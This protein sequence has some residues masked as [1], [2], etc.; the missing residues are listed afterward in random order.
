MPDTRGTSG[1]SD[2]MIVHDA[3]GESLEPAGSDRD[4]CFPT[5]QLRT[6]RILTWQ[7]LRIRM[8]HAAVSMERIYDDC[9]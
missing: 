6:C 4:R 2:A 8:C 1:L 3:C 7:L 9:A 5:E